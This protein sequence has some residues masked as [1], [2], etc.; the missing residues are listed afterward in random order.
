MVDKDKIVNSNESSRGILDYG[1]TD[2]YDLM[3][4]A[5]KSPELTLDAYKVRTLR[6]FT[7]IRTNKPVTNVWGEQR[8]SNLSLGEKFYVTNPNNNSAYDTSKFN[9]SSI[10]D[11]YI[12][13][14]LVYGRL[15]SPLERVKAE[16]YLAIKYGFMLERSYIGSSDL[17]LWDITQNKTYNNRV[18]GLYRD[19]KS[20]LYQRQGTTSYE[21][22]P[23]YS[24]LAL[25]S[26]Y[27]NEDFYSLSNKNKL[28]M[29]ERFPANTMK[30]GDYTLWGDNAADKTTVKSEEYLGMKLMSRKWLVET[31]MGGKTPVPE[32]MQWT[33]SSNLQLTNNGYKLTLKKAANETQDATLVSS[34]PLPAD[35]GHISFTLTAPL[36]QVLIKFGTQNA[37]QTAGSNDYG[38]YINQNGEVYTVIQGNSLTPIS[39]N[40][41]LVIV[42]AG[43]RIRINK[44]K[45]YFIISSNGNASAQKNQPYSQIPINPQDK[46]KSFYVSAKINQ[47]SKNE[48]T[49]QDFRTGGFIDTGNRIELSYINGRA[50]EFANYKDGQ[51]YLLVDRSGTGNFK[52]EDTELYLSDEVDLLRSKITFNNVFFDP[53]FNGKDVFTFG[54]RETNLVAQTTKTDPTCTTSGQSLSDGKIHIDI[55]RGDEAF[56]YQLIEKA[57]GTTLRS[58]AFFGKVFDINS[59]SQGDYTL[60]LKEVGGMNTVPTNPSLGY[61][62]NSQYAITASTSGSQLETTCKSPQRMDR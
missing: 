3:F 24:Y 42:K 59:L 53:D 41:W 60:K 2:G 4:H 8:Q 15:L 19:D 57:G 39:T 18:T 38:I 22:S 16:T 31:N 25:G 30:D 9:A 52:K 13:E 11:A 29:I 32:Q 26:S 14:I 49:L 6:S 55:L 51:S 45:D 7:Y 58:G 17:L 62:T 35:E 20:G 54:Y 34:V 47:A 36:G 12:P 48:V 27:D 10:F 40:R 50:S 46:D 5:G 33:A 28:L 43:D 44:T 37:S 61:Q 56:D 23:N 1:S 21:E